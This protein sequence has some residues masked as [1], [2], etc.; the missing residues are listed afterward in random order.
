MET[1]KVDEELCTRCGICSEAC[2]TGI[3]SP[4]GENTLPGVPGEMSEKCIRCGHCEAF[5][6]TG[7]LILNFSPEEKEDLPAGA[8]EISA[9]EI[10]FYLKKRRSARMYKA[11]PVPREKI[12]ELLD[13]ARYAPSGENGQ[14]VEWIVVHDP[15]KVRRVADLT[16]E[17]MKNLVAAG[18]PMS[19]FFSA[20]TGV[21]EGGY[22]VICR[23]A[24]H[25]IFAHIPEN[26]PIAPVDGIIALTYF[27]AAAPAAGIGTCWAGFVAMAASEYEPLQ[28]EIGIPAGRKCAYAMMF[29]YPKYMPQ[30]IP[31]RNPLK[32]TWK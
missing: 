15:A 20:L 24:P 18:H 30:N 19:R 10:G 7:A 5:C 25:M 16:V 22:D 2:P 4:A 26:N 27:D 9:N 13:V 11:D 1:I 29:G 6:P 32:V 28:K 23:N 17:W 31:R 3:V 14:P 21:Y 8:G 12:E